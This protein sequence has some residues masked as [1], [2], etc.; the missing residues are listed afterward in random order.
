MTQ[1]FKQ[2]LASLIG[3]LA[4]LILFF[5]LG[6][7]G[8][9][10]LLIAAALTDSGPQVKDKSVLVFDT[11]LDITDSEPTSSSGNVLG[12]ALSGDKAK[13]VTLR[14]VLDTLDKARQD[15]RIIALYLDGSRNSGN[16]DTG[17]ATLKEVRE[18]LQ[19]FRAAGKKII[20]YDVDLAKQEYYLSS[21]ADTIVLNPMGR[22][23]INGFSSQPTFYTG[24]LQKFGIGI[25]VT[26]VGKYKSAVEPFLLTKLSPENRQQLQILLNALWGDFLTTVSKSRKITP[27]QLQALANS[28]GEFMASEARQRGLVDRLAYLDEII[29]D[30]KKLTGSDEE[31]KSFRQISLTTYAKAEGKNVKQRSSKNKIA[32]VYAD[33]EIVDGQGGVQRVGGDSLAKQIREVRQDEDVKAVVLRINSPGGSV[34]GSEKIQREVLLTQKEKPVIVS[35]GNYAASGGYWIATGAEHIFAESNTITGSI[36]V[37]GLQFNI[38]KLGNDNGISWDVVK[39]SQFADSRTISRPKTPQELAIAQKSVNQIYN[40]FLDKVAQARKLP[41]PKVAQIAQGRVWSG[42]DAK[43]LGLVDKIGGIRDAIQYAAKQA[44]LENDW[45]VEE[46]SEVQSL[47]ERIL[48]KL[49]SKV[50]APKAQQPDLITAEFVKLQEDL[51]ILK[52]LNDPQGI[53]ARMPFNWRIK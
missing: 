37:F 45:Q 48:K 46:Y 18:A 19:Q 10:F 13:G 31:N 43:Q 35:M 12:D 1:F 14:T 41:K 9:V 52:A 8:L 20:A 28:Q 53:Y 21:V 25:Q 23:Q 27:Q 5:T 34:T 26:R 50:S 36:G 39:T 4:G 3:S 2:T 29:A 40:Q 38:Q 49:F 22:L 42:Q 33:G 17:L 7:S 6:A 24:A 47:E 16:M 32:L 11:S 15:K 44:E 30:L 51:A